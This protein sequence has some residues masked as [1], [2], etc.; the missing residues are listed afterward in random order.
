MAEAGMS[1][2]IYL[3]NCYWLV[4]ILVSMYILFAGFSLF[5]LLTEYLLVSRLKTRND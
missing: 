3:I 1:V 4:F 2:F 5:S